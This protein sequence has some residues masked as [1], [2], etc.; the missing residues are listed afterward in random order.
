VLLQGIECVIQQV[1]EHAADFSW[2]ELDRT[3]GVTEIALDL[4]PEFGM[5]GPPSVI[6]QLDIL[7]DKR[8]H[9]GE[10]TLARTTRSVLHHRADDAVGPSSVARDGLAIVLEIIE[11]RFNG[12]QHGGMLRKGVA[13]LVDQF[14]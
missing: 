4:D 14:A 1:Q 12:R 8:V 13:E 2:N 7:L 5:L 10:R 9:V 11:D 3:R 6:G